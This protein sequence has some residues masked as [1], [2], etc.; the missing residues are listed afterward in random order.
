MHPAHHGATISDGLARREHGGPRHA[1]ADRR[2]SA[3]APFL[4][5]WRKINRSASRATL[6]QETIR[7]LD[8]WIERLARRENNARTHTGPDRR[9]SSRPQ[10]IEE[11]RKILRSEPRDAHRQEKSRRID[12]WIARTSALLEARSCLQV[13][14]ESDWNSLVRV[15]DPVNRY[16]AMAAKVLVRLGLSR[17]L[18]QR[19]ARSHWQLGNTAKGKPIVTNAAA[20]DFSVSHVDEMVA[21]AVSSDVN[22]GIDI[23]SVDQNVSDAVID[24]FCHGEEC[25]SVSDLQSSHKMREFIRLWTFKEAYSKLVGLGHALDFKT[26]EFLLDPV[27][28]RLTGRPQALALSAQFESFWLS[29]DRTL[30]HGALAFGQPTQQPAATEIQ[31]ISLASPPRDGRSPIK[32]G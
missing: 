14:T 7:R 19:K 8:A 22:V 4:E 12:V 15:Q 18:D 6:R 30:F 11:W 28:L 10:F 27:E 23:E 13:L 21:V 20:V 17:A 5:E 2:S 3:H 32:I 1:G 16:S 26:T 9:S 29:A 31:I 24:A 25:R